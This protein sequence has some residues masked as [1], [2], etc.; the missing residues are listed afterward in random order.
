[1]GSS[2]G[3]SFSLYGQLI[4]YEREIHFLLVLR[5]APLAVLAWLLVSVLW[6]AET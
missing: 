5:G 1:M 3:Q 6:F 4:V 2:V